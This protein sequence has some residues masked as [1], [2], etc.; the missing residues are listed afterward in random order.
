M[1][2]IPN[3][4][5]NLSTE[6]SRG[7]PSTIIEVMRMLPTGYNISKIPKPVLDALFR[8][9]VPDFTLL[10]SELQQHLLTD[11]HRLIAALSTHVSFYGNY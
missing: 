7:L 10:P 1:S 9:E 3:Q 6:K 8:G 5:K 2:S 11:G 4:F